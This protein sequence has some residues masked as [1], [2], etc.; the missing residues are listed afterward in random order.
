VGGPLIGVVDVVPSP[1]LPA[2]DTKTTGSTGKVCGEMQGD[3]ATEQCD[4]RD[5]LH[6]RYSE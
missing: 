4:Q 1:V 3:Q 5:G 2:P 6:G